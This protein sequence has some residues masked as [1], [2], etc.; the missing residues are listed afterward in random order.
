[1]KINI[2]SNYLTKYRP[3]LDKKQQNRKIFLKKYIYLYF[4]LKSLFQLNNISLH[5][6]KIKKNWYT[7]LKSPGRHKKHQSHIYQEFYIFSINLELYVYNS[8][9]EL[10]QL[11]KLILKCFIF[12]SN[13]FTLKNVKS[14]FFQLEKF[15]ITI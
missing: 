9:Y 10:I 4:L 12:E 11:V 15:Y 8:K 13:L 2:K 6:K 7:F 14:S 3:N 1:M 5:I